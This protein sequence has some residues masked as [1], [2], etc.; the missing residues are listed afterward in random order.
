MVFDV[1]VFVASALGGVLVWTLL[2]YVLHRFGGHDGR[3]GNAI[4]REHLGHHARPDTFST[5]GKK[6]LLAV[7][8]LATLFVVVLAGAGVVVAT[9]LTT[10]TT[11]AWLGYERLHRLVH[12]RAPRN[13]WGAWARRHHLFHHFNPRV[14]HGVTTP[15]W[16][17]VFGTLA[18]PGIVPVP[19]KAAR[20]FPWLLDEQGLIAARWV[21]DYR[22][23]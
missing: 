14:N 7:P 13:A 2:E 12:V 23:A 20:A 9:G 17:W 1:V 18:R 22:L 10:G 19:K 15:L 6:L 5:T 4:R 8:V 16:D 3:F 21:D 11:G